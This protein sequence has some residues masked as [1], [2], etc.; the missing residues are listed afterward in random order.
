MTFAR[1]RRCARWWLMV[2]G[3]GLCLVSTP[4]LAADPRPAAEPRPAPS[5][6]L[7]KPPPARGWLRPQKAASS[8]TNGP[9]S[10]NSGRMALICV[11]VAALA[12][13]AFLVKRRRR[14]VIKR[15]ASELSVITAARVGSKADV[16][17]VQVGGRRLL[18]G[19]TE[20]QVSRL[21]WLDGEPDPEQL[22]APYPA[23]SNEAVLPAKRLEAR[24]VAAVV[25]PSRERRTGRGFGDVLRSVLSRSTTVEDPAVT[26]A[27]TTEDVVTHSG[28]TRVA[29]PAGAPEMVDIEGQARGLILRL[30]KRA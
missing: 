22:D 6:S 12:G 16:V 19:V 5:A 24:A 14:L 13:A 21:C 7:A 8:P 15:T 17:V 11:V 3:L 18:L 28:L 1:Q 4:A 2:G 9:T 26:I 29:S 27:R 23:L 25:S 10:P 20:S 30:Q